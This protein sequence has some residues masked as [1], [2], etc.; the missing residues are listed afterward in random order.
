MTHAAIH[1]FVNNV[2]VVLAATQDTTLS[3][4]MTYCIILVMIL[5]LL[6]ASCQERTRSS[7]KLVMSLVNMTP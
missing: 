4:Q 5:F 3:L 6:D 2:L 7:R 1:S